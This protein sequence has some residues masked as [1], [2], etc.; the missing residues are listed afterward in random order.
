MIPLV[1]NASDYSRKAFWEW[2]KGAIF[3]LMVSLSVYVN[4]MKQSHFHPS[5]SYGACAHKWQ[6]S[7]LEAMM[8][9]VR[10]ESMRQRTDIEALVGITGLPVVYIYI[11]A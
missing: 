2:V 8:N 11:Y 1:H 9:C 4:E 5:S 3:S 6:E 10:W 7:G